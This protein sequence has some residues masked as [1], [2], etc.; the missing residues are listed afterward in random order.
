MKK[1][2]IFQIAALALVAAGSSQAAYVTYFGEDLNNSATSQ[3]SAITNSLGAQTSF[4][5]NLTGAGVENFETR[6]GSAP[7]ALTFAGFGGGSLSATLTGNG[8]VGTN[9]VGGTNGAG[10]Y[11]VPGGTRYRQTDA[12]G[13]FSVQFG[14]AIAAFGYYGIDIG[15]FGGTVSLDMYNGGSLVGSVNV[16]NTVGSNGSTDGS[17]LYFGLIAGSSS[18]LF[19]EVRFRTTLGGGDIFAFDSFT[20]AEQ[21]QVNPS[22]PEPTSLALVGLALCAA[23]WARKGKQA[24]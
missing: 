3:V 5:S 20:I 12:G 19:N 11:S 14:Q 15:D 1:A 8:A 21:R 23:G 7:L 13:N 24:A 9:A 22:V 17:V 6:T 10:R 16:P 18:E 4:L 2:W